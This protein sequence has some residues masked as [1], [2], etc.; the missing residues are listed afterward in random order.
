MDD[1]IRY[2]LTELQDVGGRGLLA[3]ARGATRTGSPR[4]SRAVATA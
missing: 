1:D 2:V 4:C 3:A